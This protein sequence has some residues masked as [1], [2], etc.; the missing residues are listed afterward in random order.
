MNVIVMAWYER[1]HNTAPK[2]MSR[3]ASA[4]RMMDIM[5][6]TCRGWMGVL[7]LRRV[8]LVVRQCRRA[9]STLTRP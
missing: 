8:A 3:F 9:L 7:L 4:S 2:E 5:Q 1:R 6:P